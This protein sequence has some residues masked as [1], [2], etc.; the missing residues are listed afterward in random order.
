MISI[1]CKKERSKQPIEKNGFK[2]SSVWE[3]KETLTTYTY[4][5]DTLDGTLIDRDTTVELFTHNVVIKTTADSNIITINNFEHYFPIPLYNSHYNENNDV[6]MQT[7]FFTLSNGGKTQYE[8]VV[9]TD[10]TYVDGINGAWIEINN[11]ENPT[12]LTGYGSMQISTFPIW[13]IASFEIIGT[14]L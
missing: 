5:F 12:S 9:W 2:D 6:E 4:T 14:K 10:F 7:Y 8:Y 1:S 3:I 13:K 11:A